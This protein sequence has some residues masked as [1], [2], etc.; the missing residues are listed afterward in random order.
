MLTLDFIVNPIILLVAMVGAALVGFIT[1]KS[2]L[3]RKENKIIQLENEVMNSHAEIL[4]LQKAYIALEHQLKDQSIPVIP[5]T[6][7]N[8]KESPKEK[9]LK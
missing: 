3:A 8:G 5:M 9:I 1:G 4:D 2:K 6:K 7:I